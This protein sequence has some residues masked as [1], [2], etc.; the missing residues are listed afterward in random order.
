[1][2][3]ESRRGCP[4]PPRQRDDG[5]A[6]S[7][8]S[9]IPDLR[10]T[11]DVNGGKG[12]GADDVPPHVPGRAASQ[13]LPG[14]SP[15]LV[16]VLTRG[17]RPLPGPPCKGLREWCTVPSAPSENGPGRQPGQPPDKPPRFDRC[18]ARCTLGTPPRTKAERLD[19]ERV[20]SLRTQQR[21]ESQCQVVNPFVGFFGLID[22]ESVQFSVLGLVQASTESLIL[23][24]DE[25]WRRA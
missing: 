4:A 6:S 11:Q 24:Q 8:T 20:R 18:G 22:I 17:G 25:R 13:P 9:V 2:R 16:T 5:S 23:A 7:T 21:A 1:M 15:V 14:T 19:Y 3:R 10:V 12:D